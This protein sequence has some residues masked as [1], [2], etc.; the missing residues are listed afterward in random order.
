MT[1]VAT[2]TAGAIATQGAATMN[3]RLSL[4]MRPQSEDGG[5]APSPRNPSDA[6]KRIA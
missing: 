5:W 2:A 1:S 6:T 3:R 4:I